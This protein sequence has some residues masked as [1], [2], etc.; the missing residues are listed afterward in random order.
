MKKSE[1]ERLTPEELQE[2]RNAYGTIMRV[3]EQLY[4]GP[5]GAMQNREYFVARDCARNCDN[6]LGPEF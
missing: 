5:R 6:I 1:L 2:V 4:D 3:L